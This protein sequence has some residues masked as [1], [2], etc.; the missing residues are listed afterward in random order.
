MLSPLFSLEITMSNTSEFYLFANETADL[1]CDAVR[2]YF[3][4]NESDIERAEF[5]GVVYVLLLGFWRNAPRA[6]AIPLRILERVLYKCDSCVS[7]SDVPI[8]MEAIRKEAL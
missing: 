3:D 8:L 4:V 5:Q 7:P 6:P 2:K 1:V